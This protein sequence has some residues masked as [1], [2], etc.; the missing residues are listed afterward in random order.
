M[1]NYDPKDIEERVLAL[2]KKNN[3]FE[4]YLKHRKGEKKFYF[5]DGPPYA[6]G[7]IHM[8]HALNKVMKDFY[9]RFYKML[10]YDVWLQPGF[11]THGVPIENKVEKKLDMKFKKDIEKMGVEKFIEECRNFATEYIGL[12]SERFMDI[13]VW[14]DWGN[15]YLTLNN[16][17]MESAWHTFK[18]AFDK[19]LLYKGNYPIHV[20]PH[21]ETVVAYSEIE[22][23]KID[24]DSIYV[25][26]P[27]KNE[28][29]TFLLIWTT[30]PW[31]LPANT[32][33]MV[34][35]NFDYS[36]VRIGNEYLIIASNLVDRIMK[37][38]NIKEYSVVETV[39]GN[40]LVELQYDNPLKE[41]IPAQYNI[42]GRVVISEQFVTLEEGTGLVHTA[43]GH[44]KEDYKVGRE[45]NLPALSPVNLDGTFTE[46]AGFLNRMFVKDGNKE[47]VGKLEEGGYLFGKE[48]IKH[49]YPMCWR[50]KS[51]LIMLSVPQWF[52]KISEFR[53]KL[54]ENNEKVRWSPEWA[55]KRFGNWLESLDDWPISRQRYW[56]IPLPIWICEKCNEVKV[57][58]SFDELPK[59]LKDYHR[60]YIDEI[61]MKCK[62]GGEMRRIP[63][64]LDVWFDSGVSSW[65]S[66]GYPKKKELFKRLWPA[67]LNIEGRDMFRGWWNSQIITSQ[68]TF[69]K[70]PFESILVHGLIMD[71]NK[72]KMSKSKGNIVAPKE[73]MDKYG[74]DILRYYLLTTSP[75]EDFYF[76]WENVEKTMRFFTVF[77]NTVNFIET[78]CKKAKMEGL[79]AEDKW[80]ISRVNN[81]V[82]KVEEMN[83]NLSFS[84]SVELIQNF[85]VEDLSH[86]YI[87]LIRDRVRPNY[88][89][90]DGEAAEATSYYVLEKIVKVLA[91]VCPFITEHIYQ[92]NFDKES[93]HLSDWPKAEGKMISEKL[94]AE[95]DEVKQIIESANAHRQK[96]GIK[97]KYILSSVTIEGNEGHLDAAK[98]FHKVIEQMVNVKR[99]LSVLDEKLE[100]C[101]V[102]LNTEITP[103][104]KS[105]W[106]ISEFIRN[107]QDARK[108][109]ELKMKDKAEIYLQEDE[110]FLK[111]KGDI[112]ESTGS[113]LIFGKIVGKR[114]E[115][116]FEGKKYEFGLKV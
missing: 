84:K 53:E 8:G 1:A 51:Q 15:P 112:E 95:M 55:K 98:D 82:K 29:N 106:L 20:C 34:N 68:I 24:D 42:T 67:D 22:Y 94:E 69:D 33:I 60:P 49:D 71:M 114:F 90:K 102:I 57:V 59:K 109:S 46:D 40:N 87:K 9:I 62:C 58:G 76:S 79:V 81:L 35:P 73:V 19:G 91:P 70:K 37:K 32:G 48:K 108:K 75:G 5:M 74:R 85:I 23:Q 3:T 96:N 13:G 65:A 21:C 50:C 63:D 83:K 17:Y 54:L 6:N 36:K 97:L 45:F 52:F 18:I 61:V 105:E 14:M 2:W 26:F 44:G 64:V 38:F 110:L 39:K 111:N 78:Y 30:T 99:V 25:K 101:K 103:E 16:E 77:Y 104:L 7:E 88:K 12:M 56:G 4:K 92:K 113:K 27:V 31:T 28:E 47:I 43:P 93:I 107:I 86:M 80:I 41:K 116:E 89:G 10:G 115:F 100:H 72:I 11:D 66:L